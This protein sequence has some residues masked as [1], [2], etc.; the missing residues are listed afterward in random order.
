MTNL[1]TLLNAAD[2]AA[3]TESNMQALDQSL[4]FSRTPSLVAG[5][6]TAIVGPPAAGTFTFGALWIDAL[7]GLWFCTGAGTPGTWT[8]IGPGIA[9]A[10]PGAA[11]PANYILWRSDIPALKIYSGGAWVSPVGV[12]F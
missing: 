9:A 3:I 1:L 2:K 4:A 12:I 11:P 6:P 5:V 10:A 7:C 8:Q